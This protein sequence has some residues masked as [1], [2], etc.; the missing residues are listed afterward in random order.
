MTTTNIHAFNGEVKVTSNLSVNTNTLHVNA[1]TGNVGIGKINPSYNL[2]V[3][4][5]INANNI[6]RNGTYFADGLQWSS[7]GDDIYYDSYGNI[8]IGTTSASKQLEVQGDIRI[9]NASVSSKYSELQARI[10]TYVSGGGGG[11]GG[12]ETETTVYPSDGPIQGDEF[13]KA[14]GGVAISTNGL[15]AI[16]G[17]DTGVYIFYYNGSSWNQQQKIAAP[18]SD[19]HVA[20][21]VAISSDGTRVTFFNAVDV[22]VYSRSYSTWSLES[23][24][25]E[26]PTWDNN[27]Y[28]F[29]LDMDENGETIVVGDPRY[30]TSGS[31]S[32]RNNGALYVFQRSG[33]SWTQ[34]AF[35]TSTDN[36]QNYRMGVMVAISRDGN[37]ICAGIAPSARTAGVVY[38]YKKSGSSWDDTSSPDTSLNFGLANEVESNYSPRMSISDVQSGY[39]YITIASTN[40]IVLGRY[41]FSSS[42]YST[43]NSL[44][45]SECS[46]TAISNDGL[47]ALGGSA[48][49]VYKYV[50]NSTTWSLESTITKFDGVNDYGYGDSLSMKTSNIYAVGEPEWV[51]GATNN[52]GRAYLTTGGSSGGSSNIDVN[53]AALYVSTNV[54]VTGNISSFTGKHLCSSEYALYPGQIVVA[55]KNQY[56]NLNGGLVTG[57]DAIRSRESLPV[58]SLSNVVNDKNV[59][60]VVYSNEIRQDTRKQNLGGICVNTHKE[61]GDDRVIINS[62]GEGAMWVVNTNGSISAGDYITSSNVPGYGQRQDDDVLHNYTVAKIT[63][64]CDFN[65][66][67]QPIQRIKKDENGIN[68]LDSQGRLQW[69]DT[70]ETESPYEIKY[71]TST[72]SQTDQANA[73]YIAAY[74]GCTFHCG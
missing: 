4:G 66:Q 12:G 56:I 72:G 15:Y 74:V 1:Q 32:E 40:T 8:S 45:C 27:G 60:G 48:Y 41:L 23:T 9:S 55:D 59:I 43:L 36:E 21:S 35:M 6:Y 50:R 17:A 26:S 70:D 14:A 28:G 69:E 18:F 10:S 34:E 53:V 61:L 46:G 22:V 2:D 57:K 64:D 42:T 62:L 7:S 24:L 16:V 44:S 11:G 58:V 25:S 31:R 51:S 39:Y 54:E 5:S 20:H 33:T 30:N 38:F 52:A 73:A 49:T 68:V 47:Y 63:M 13:G 65:P 67:Q 3:N 37:L 19:N 29:N 71:I